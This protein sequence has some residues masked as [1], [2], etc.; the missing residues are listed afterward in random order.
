MWTSSPKMTARTQRLSTQ[1]PAVDDQSPAFPAKCCS[2]VSR[3]D[4]IRV[5]WCSMLSRKCDIVPSRSPRGI[6][7]SCGQCPLLHTGRSCFHGVSRRAQWLS[8]LPGFEDYIPPGRTASPVAIDPGKSISL[9]TA[10][11]RGSQRP[12]AVYTHI[13]FAWIT[14]LAPLHTPPPPTHRV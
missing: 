11:R 14:A 4:Y 5:S 9:S 1:T 12:D 2:A 8:L 7:R 3:V 10:G 13:S 6:Q